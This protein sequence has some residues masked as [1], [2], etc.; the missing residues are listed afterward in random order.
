MKT[1]SQKLQIMAMLIGFGLSTQG[2]AQTADILEDTDAVLNSDQ[3]DIDGMYEQPRES[4]AQRIEKMR[5]QLEKKNEEMVS[6]KIEDMRI[7]EEQKLA[8]KLQKAFN[9]GNL[10]NVDEVS[11]AQAAPAQVVAVAPVVE[12]KKTEIKRNKIIPVFGVTT[13]SGEQIEF[14]SSFNAGLQAESLITDRISMG[15]GINYTSMKISDVANNFNNNYNYNFG[16]YNN[17]GTNGR[18]IDYSNI[19]IEANSKFFITDIDSSFRPYIGA[20]LG[21]NRLSMSYNS[22]NGAQNFNIGNQNFGQEA[23]RSSSISG[24]ILGGMEASFT[25]NI[26]VTL[27][28][29]YTRALTSG[30]AQDQGTT[31]QQSP[32]Q[33]RLQNIGEA[34]EDANQ[35]SVGAG[36]VVRF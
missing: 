1:T 6:K 5:K 14:E 36:L 13:F 10:G 27:D 35:I 32:D 2:F 4:A 26:G 24:S 29:R 22:D 3:I 16:Y 19:A 18:E 34:I 7:K 12:E 8:K 9:G 25:E 30:F 15:L 11:T 20:A 28:L 31:V 33:L 17:F 23:Q 21:Y